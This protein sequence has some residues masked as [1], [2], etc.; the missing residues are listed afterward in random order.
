M[1]EAVSADSV[2][3]PQRGTDPSTD[4][5]TASEDDRQ[6]RRS[7]E[8]F[9]RPEPQSH[10]HRYADESTDERACRLAYLDSTII[11]VY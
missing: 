7:P 6:R 11:P 1:V 10:E 3:I 4:R 8:R 9:A 2:W 5:C